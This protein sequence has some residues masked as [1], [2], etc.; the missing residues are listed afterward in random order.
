[1]FISDITRGHFEALAER[2]ENAKLAT[3]VRLMLAPPARTNV[4]GRARW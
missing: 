3:A 2:T 1:V 4:T